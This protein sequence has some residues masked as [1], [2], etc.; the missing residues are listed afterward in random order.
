MGRKGPDGILEYAT[1]FFFM[2]PMNLDKGTKFSNHAYILEFILTHIADEAHCETLTSRGIKF[3]SL[4]DI[5]A[6]AFHF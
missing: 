3:K 4:M 1:Y 6:A 2:Q 5:R